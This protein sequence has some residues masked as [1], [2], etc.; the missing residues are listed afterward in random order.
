MPNEKEI[1]EQK[2]IDRLLPSVPT[3][4]RSKQ[5]L[6]KSQIQV[7]GMIRREKRRLQLLKEAKKANGESSSEELSDNYSDNLDY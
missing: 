6:H 7:R 4:A 3:K 5:N 1:K 2:M